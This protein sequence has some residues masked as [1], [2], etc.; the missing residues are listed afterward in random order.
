MDS[1]VLNQA[2]SPPPPA[3][4]SKRSAFF[5]TRESVRESLHKMYIASCE[6]LLPPY[7]DLLFEESMNRFALKLG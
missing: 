4:V 6:K 2:F 3:I 1:S 5:D 7:R